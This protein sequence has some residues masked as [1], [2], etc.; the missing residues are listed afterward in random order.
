MGV[1]R[2]GISGQG[3]EV[4]KALGFT[5]EHIFQEYKHLNKTNYLAVK[6]PVIQ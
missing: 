1:D 2:F 4:V 3:A 6:T 5:L